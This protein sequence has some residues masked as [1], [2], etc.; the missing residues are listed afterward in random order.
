MKL[1]ST[2]VQ[3][4]QYSIFKN[5]ELLFHTSTVNNAVNVWKIKAS[6]ATL[7]P[8]V[9]ISMEITE[10]KVN[11]RT[12]YNIGLYDVENLPQKFPK[13][14]YDYRDTDYHSFFGL[15]NMVFD[16]LY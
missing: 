11:Y 2:F 8:E 14:L 13:T 12:L 5:H 10:F 7:A 4:L 16:E 6:G 15:L 3:F 9:T 1:P